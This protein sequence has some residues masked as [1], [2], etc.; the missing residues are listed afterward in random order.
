MYGDKRVF[1]L[2]SLTWIPALFLTFFSPSLSAGSLLLVK[3][4]FLLLYQPAVAMQGLAAINLL[5]ILE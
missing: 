3:D 4:F 5:L 2:V 1:Y